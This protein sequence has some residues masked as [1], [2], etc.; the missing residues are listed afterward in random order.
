MALSN[1]G[2]ISFSFLLLSSMLLVGSIEIRP[3]D[4]QE[5]TRATLLHDNFDDENGGSGMQVYNRF[6][7]WDVLDGSVDLIGNGYF[8]IYPGNGLYVDLD[9]SSDGRIASKTAFS[10]G[11][12]TCELSF[13]LGGSGRGDTNT[14]DMFLG[15][16]Y[17]ETFT[18]ASDEPLELVSR[19]IE[20]REKNSA[21]LV[22]D[23]TRNN[24]NTYGLIL[25]NVSLICETTG[26]PKD[27]PSPTGFSLKD[28][29]SVV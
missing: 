24:D 16:V 2:A 21:R 6:A 10:I 13:K 7:N 26:T 22:F 20:L 28:R 15:G 29:K 14:L 11:P 27:E 4:A 25:D 18:L 1:L 5:M 9:G 23:H 8:D 17:A 3:A 12:G 19:T